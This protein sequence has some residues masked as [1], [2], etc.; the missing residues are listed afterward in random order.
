M[1]A[2]KG[3]DGRVA[4]GVGLHRLSAEAPEAEA[5]QLELLGTQENSLEVSD[6]LSSLKTAGQGA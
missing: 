3:A 5:L 6:F 1:R 2:A 4:R